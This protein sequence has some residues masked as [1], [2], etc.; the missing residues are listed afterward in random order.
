MG[1]NWSL[2]SAPFLALLCPALYCRD[3]PFPGSLANCLPIGFGSGVPC[4]RLKWGR[5]EKPQYLHVPSCLWWHLWGQWHLW[6]WQYHFHS[7][8]S[9]WP[10]PPLWLPADPPTGLFFLTLS[11]WGSSGFPLLLIFGSPHHPMFGFWIF[12]PPIWL[13][14][15]IK[16][17]PCLSS[18]SLLA[19]PHL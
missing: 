7:P 1:Q 12:P 17:P 4:G 3:L 9:H 8:S 13:I 6:P 2:F 5:G 14:S 19:G 10:A 16:S 11:P 18:F 15:I